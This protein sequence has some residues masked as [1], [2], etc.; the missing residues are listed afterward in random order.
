[1]D[2][3]LISDLL[4][5]FTGDCTIHPALQNK[6][7]DHKAISLVLNKSKKK[8]A[9][10]YSISKKELNDDLLGYLVHS[11]VSETYLQ[12][13]A[14]DRIDGNNKNFLLNTCGT[15]KALIRDCGPPF[16]LR[17]GTEFGRAEIEARERKI[18]RIQVL[19]QLLNIHV[20]ESGIFSCDPQILLET[21]LL[22]IKNDV[23]SHQSFMRKQ[24]NQKKNW[25][26]KKLTSL[27][28]DYE[29][30]QDEIR[31]VENELNL[32]LDSEIRQ[33]LENFRQFDIL[34]TEKMTPRFLALCKA[35]KSNA[36]LDHILD[37]RGEAFRDE[38]ARD[39]YICQFYQRIYSPAAG[40]ANRVL[41]ENCIENFLGPEICNNPI[42]LNSKLTEAEKNMF[43][44]NITL[45]EL[46]IAVQKLNEKSAGGLDGIPTCFIKKFW[47]FFRFPLMN[48]ANFA[49][50]HGNLTQSFNSAG[51]K[52]IPKKGD[53]S[54][55]KNWRPI[56]LLNSI[57]KVIS[58]ALDN[59]LKKIT[60]I[61][62]SR[63]QKGFTSRRQLHECIINITETI[64]YAET[65]N[66]PAFVLALDMAKAFDTV[67]HDYMDKVYKF[68]G[69]GDNLIKMLNVIS[70]GRTAHFIKEDGRT[71]PPISLGT[72]FPQGN[73][74]SP[75]QFNIGE[76]IL[77]FKIELDS[78]IRGI[79][80]MFNNIPRI[81]AGA[82][83][84][85]GGGGGP[86]PGFRPGAGT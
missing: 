71:S 16:E 15:I 6:L 22:N 69:F 19:C 5:D 78:N 26:L 77:I 39:E 13:W 58:K 8:L 32:F 57:F 3:F 49:F 35:Q 28:N 76:Q 83:G 67:R 82:P 7:F 17:T 50:Q 9:E 74:P 20:L 75:N 14:G 48:Y 45:Q 65:E 66:I 37:D 56:S 42:V 21:L 54:K 63:G 2:F 18:V 10:R 86:G 23:T 47:H 41:E 12:H 60:E 11:S 84:G 38:A 85:G 64:A 33:E 29:N 44:A 43:D 31:A 80:N 73:A 36:S 70:T 40:T 52:L 61:V 51:I 4:L 62:L 53:I 1:L 81:I 30:N 79:M 46:D 27:K 34:H 25:L 68:F 59:R 72:G 24:K 55:I